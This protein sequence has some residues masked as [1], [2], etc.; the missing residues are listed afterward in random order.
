MYRSLPCNE[1][2]AFDGIPAA[3]PTANADMDG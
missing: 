2:I 1:S 3:N